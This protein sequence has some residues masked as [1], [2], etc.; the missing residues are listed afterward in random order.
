MKYALTL[1][2]E[3]WSREGPVFKSGPVNM[4]RVGG[5]PEGEEAKITN[6][7]APHRSDWRILR[8]RGDEQCGWSGSYDS[9][10]VALAEL[11]KQYE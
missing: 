3:G 1:H 9:A 5:M 6:F 4:Y 8:I 11:Q 2:E 7:G 10:D